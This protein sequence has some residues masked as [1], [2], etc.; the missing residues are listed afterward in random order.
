VFWG[1]EL[2][3]RVAE[4]AARIFVENPSIARRDA[5]DKAMREAGIAK[6]RLRSADIVAT[7]TNF[8]EAFKLA[9][10]REKKTRAETLI[11]A[12]SSAPR[13]EDQ[14]SAAPEPEAEPD[15]GPT[16]AEIVAS[17]PFA[18]IWERLGV[19]VERFLSRADE[20]ASGIEG[21]IRR[22]GLNPVH[23][24]PSAAFDPE[25][26][27]RPPRVVI[28]GLLG[29]QQHAISN[30]IGR[31]AEL[32]FPRK[33]NAGAPLPDADY[34]VLMARFVRHAD[35]DRLFSTFGR[36][37]VS[38]VT[39]GLDTLSGVIRRLVEDHKKRAFAAGALSAVGN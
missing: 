38:V 2:T 33:D 32:R 21:A 28:V 7:A 36:E 8:R 22:L 18:L 10:E 6:E 30:R 16:V 31:A 5:I 20:R 17:A 19:E 37:R 14:P 35:Q 29:D 26:R 1:Q 9:I 3:D 24:L 27:V 25:G 13:A 15:P 34:A 39:G 11:R 4:I 12:A 23:G